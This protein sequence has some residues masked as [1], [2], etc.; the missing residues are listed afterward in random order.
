MKY[1]YLDARISLRESG[2]RRKNLSR[3]K[4]DLLEK[5]FSAQDCV[6]FA[7]AGSFLFS[8][9]GVLSPLED[10][11][12]AIMVLFALKESN[13]GLCIPPNSGNFVRSS[14]AFF[15]FCLF[16]SSRLH[17]RVCADRIEWAVGQFIIAKP[18]VLN[19]PQ[20]QL[21]LISLP[22]NSSDN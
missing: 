21:S 18:F 12:D 11:A 5:T 8:A 17:Y 20:K 19:V 9:V 22:S 13:Y 1:F 14:S 15:S 6:S 10:A 4:R 7:E 3:Q 16:V 2:R